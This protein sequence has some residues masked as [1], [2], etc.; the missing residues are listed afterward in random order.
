MTPTER[1][2][3]RGELAAAALDVFNEKGYGAA[4]MRDIAARVG[5]LKGSVYH[6]T[7]SKEELLA[8][9]F[10]QAT[11]RT[12]AILEGVGRSEQPA[13]ERL[14]AFVEGWS[15]WYLENLKVIRV[16]LQEWKHLSGER[17]QRAIATRR[18]A[19][20]RVVRLL[21][22][23]KE[24]GAAPTDLDCRYA[25]LLIL[26][27]INGLPG[28]YRPGQNEPAEL[29]AETYSNLLVGMV[30]HSGPREPLAAAAR[31]RLDGMI[32]AVPARDGG[33]EGRGETV[34]RAA[35]EVFHERGYA[36]ASMREVAERSQMNKGSLYHYIDSKEALLA[37]IFAASTERTFALLAEIEAMPGP[38]IT[39]LGAF[40]ECWSRWYLL[41]VKVITV[42]I[43]DWKHLSGERLQRAIAIRREA[44]ERVA[45]LLEE[46]KAEGD[47]PADLDCRYAALLILSAINGLPGWYRPDQNESAERVAANYSDLLVGMVSNGKET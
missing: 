28:W 45:R 23:A 15:R 5:L 14:A 38:A 25:S 41:N 30:T 20:E 42:Y 8:R 4:S 33:A 12:F 39:R 34:L 44:Y 47:A 43:D 7:D 22:E 46:I 31:T 16:Y 24:E 26:S 40:V 27:A 36:G 18:E 1:R 10:E 35:I 21:E 19:Y 3:R 17:L 9:I 13:I 37:E 32:A 2:D 29:V 6:Y 11:D